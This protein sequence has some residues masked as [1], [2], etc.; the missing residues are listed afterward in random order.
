MEVRTLPPPLGL[1]P[2]QFHELDFLE[3]VAVELDT[4]A[5]DAV[6]CKAKPVQGRAVA[7]LR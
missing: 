5:P 3:T 7:H 6:H 4:I 1:V 2:F